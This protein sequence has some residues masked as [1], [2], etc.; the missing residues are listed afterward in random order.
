MVIVEMKM[1]I[2]TTPMA[3]IL[4]LMNLSNIT[5]PRSYCYIRNINGFDSCQILFFVVKLFH[6]SIEWMLCVQLYSFSNT[7][8]QCLM[9]RT[10]FIHIIGNCKKLPPFLDYRPLNCR[11]PG[12][13]KTFSKRSLTCSV[14]L[15]QSV[16]VFIVMTFLFVFIRIFFPPI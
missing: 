13:P 7:I 16:L 9:W 11:N 8:I 3:Q 15:N 6:V 14:R 10:M 2:V 12:W 1:I 4:V 5:L